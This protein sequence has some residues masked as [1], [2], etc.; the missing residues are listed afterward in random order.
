MEVGKSGGLVTVFNIY[1]MVYD[2][3]DAFWESIAGVPQKWNIQIDVGPWHPS[4]IYILDWNKQVHMRTI[5]VELKGNNNCRDS[6]IMCV[7][8]TGFCYDGLASLAT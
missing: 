7:W 2:F 1:Y 4:I 8:T 6:G 3:S 5:K